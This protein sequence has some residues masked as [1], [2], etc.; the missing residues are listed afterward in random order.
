MGPGSIKRSKML[1]RYMDAA[2][3]MQS[4]VGFKIQKDGGPDC[5]PKHLRVGINSAHVSVDALTQLLLQHGIFTIEELEQQLAEAMERE[6]ER[7][8]TE[9]KATYGTGIKLG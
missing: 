6:A 3:A 9:L 4:G 8:E 2:H 5:T 7:Y 1:D